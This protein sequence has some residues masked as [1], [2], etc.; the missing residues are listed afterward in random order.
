M[1][2]VKKLLSKEDWI[3]DVMLKVDFYTQEILFW[4]LLNEMV[5]TY[6]GSYK[7]KKQRIKILKRI[8]KLNELKSEKQNRKKLEP[9]ASFF[10]KTL[11]KYYFLIKHNKKYKEK[12][13][14]CN[15]ISIE[16]NIEKARKQLDLDSEKQVKQYFKKYKIKEKIAKQVEEYRKKLK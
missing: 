16:K 7:Y 6:S 4:F 10:N 2:N 15:L 5:Q 1:R 12:Y 13:F 3:A 14:E 8:G 9:I 11:D